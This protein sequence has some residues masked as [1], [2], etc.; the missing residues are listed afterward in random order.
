MGIKL[1]SIFNGGADPGMSGTGARAHYGQISRN[2]SSTWEGCA[3]Y[4]PQFQAVFNTG[5]PSTFSTSK[6]GQPITYTSDDTHQYRTQIFGLIS[7]SQSSQSSSSSRYVQGT[8]QCGE[9]GNAGIDIYSDGTY[10]HPYSRYADGNVKDLL[11]DSAINSDHTNRR[12]VYL[13]IS[14]VVRAVDRLY[15]TYNYPLENTADYSVSSLNSNMRGSASYNRS[16]QELTILSYSSSNGS[17][18]VYTFANVDFDRYPSPSVALAR[19]EVVR[20]NSTVSLS[21]NW[22][23]NSSES[24][25]SLKPVVTDSGKVYVSVFFESSSLTLYE[26]TRSGTSAITGTY[27]TALGT[28]TSYGRDQGTAYGQRTITSRDGTSVATFC[29]YYYYGS[30]IKCFMIDK[31]NNTYSTYAYNDTS[32]GHQI[33]PW[34]DNGWIFIYCGNGYA[35]N[36]G[37]NYIQDSFVKSRTG[38]FSSQGQKSYFPYYPGPNTT[39]YPGFSQ[40]VDYVLLPSTGSKLDY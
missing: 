14:G 38:G 18:N 12:I 17:Y 40:V 4:D 9:F 37:G 6:I 27:V 23:V 28:T 34:L 39:N 25:Y 19:P 1:S 30:G 20:T 21:S 8:N 16:R 36:Y 11:N 31:T 33:V 10:S 5:R 22:S 26:F 32:Y 29:P 7:A 2:T 24:Y 35:G 15:G 3:W 13:L